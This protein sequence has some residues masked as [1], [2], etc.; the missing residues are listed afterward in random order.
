MRHDHGSMGYYH[1]SDAS[2]SIYV[3]GSDGSDPT[4]VRDFPPAERPVPDWR[5]LP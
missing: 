4:L 1:E 5:P 2:T 3:M